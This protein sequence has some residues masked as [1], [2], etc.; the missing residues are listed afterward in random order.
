LNIWTTILAN[1]WKLTSHSSIYILSNL[2]CTNYCKGWSI[3]IPTKSSI[4]I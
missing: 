2:S 4:E 3:C 1:T